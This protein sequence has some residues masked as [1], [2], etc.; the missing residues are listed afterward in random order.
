MQLNLQGTAFS[1]SSDSGTSRALISAPGALPPTKIYQV[2]STVPGGE[3][4]FIRN[5]FRDRVIH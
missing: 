1:L 2:G 4:L 3:E 5:I